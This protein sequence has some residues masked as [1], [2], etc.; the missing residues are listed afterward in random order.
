VRRYEAVHSGSA[1]HPVYLPAVA[2]FEAAVARDPR[3]PDLRLS[4]ALALEKLGDEAAARQHVTL[5]LDLH[6]KLVAKHPEHVLRLPEKELRQ[7]RALL[8]RVAR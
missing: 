1:A 3:R 7:A 6:E 5:A 2:E 8:R 4:L